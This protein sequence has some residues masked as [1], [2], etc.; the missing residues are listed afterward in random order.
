MRPRKDDATIDGAVLVTLPPLVRLV[1][2]CRLVPV[3]TDFEDVLDGAGD[4]ALAEAA[5]VRLVLLDLELS[6]SD[7]PRFAFPG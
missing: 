6:A 4:G 7:T 5:S 1:D 2:A 3:R